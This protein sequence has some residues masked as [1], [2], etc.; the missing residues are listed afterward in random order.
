ME[1][2]TGREFKNR[3]YENFSLIGKA[4]SAPKRLEIIDILCQAERTVDSLSR[5]AA[6][7]VANTSRHL[8]VLRAARLVEAR[9]DG[10]FVYYRLADGSVW[11][12]LSMVRD[13]A[14][15]RIAEVNQIVETFF[16]S[17]DELEPIN[18]DN[19]IERVK[20][21]LVVVIDVRPKE[22]YLAGH[23]SG[24]RSLPVDEIKS[25]L[26]ELPRDVEIV[27]YCRGPYCVFS[28]EAVEI[29]RSREFSAVRFEDGVRDWSDAGLPITVGEEA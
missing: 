7:S 1:D 23:I 27:A 17:R 29:L 8:Q 4:L 25:R 20:A 14:S 15:Q 12:L 5:E 13:L 22:E 3:L 18:R 26:V 19:L 10:N 21:G 11:M 6:I 24:A 28:L 9:K 16:T 2:L